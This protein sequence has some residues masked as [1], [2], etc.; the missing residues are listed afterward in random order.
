M[1]TKSPLLQFYV[2]EKMIWYQGTPI[3]VS[4]NDIENF[5]TSLPDEISH[6]KDSIQFFTYFSE[7]YYKVERKKTYYDFGTKLYREIAYD[8]KLEQN[9]ALYLFE[10]CKIFYENSRLTQI[11]DL[12]NSLRSSILQMMKITKDNRRKYR[13]ELLKNSDW[14][15]AQDIPFSQDE[16][17][18]WVEYRQYLRDMTS[19]ESWEMN[20][21]YSKIFPIDP[22]AYKIQ[23]PNFEVEYLETSDQFF[24]QKFDSKRNELIELVKTLNLP[25]INL[26]DLEK[27]EYINFINRMNYILKK[28]GIED[29]SLE[30]KEIEVSNEDSI[31]DKELVISLSQ[32]G[33][34][35][36][37]VDEIRENL[38]KTGKYT[39]D[40]I[41]IYVQTIDV[42]NSLK[43]SE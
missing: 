13:D 15:Q 5:L 40:Q 37:L 6:P 7:D 21:T 2:P 1:T 42:L 43:F 4:R 24:S 31:F 10:Q 16:R 17:Q 20:T 22:V 14:T 35:G 41:E 25:S 18:R 11:D 32:S 19:L 3:S 33:Y 38:K 23:Y 29:V 28:V 36:N 27:I 39:E 26:S 30:T 34:T 12:K 8:Y 9:D